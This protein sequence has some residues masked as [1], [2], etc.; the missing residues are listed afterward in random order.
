MACCIVCETRIRA[1]AAGGS[2]KRKTLAAW[3]RGG[4]EMK[5]VLSNLKLD[6][7]GDLIGAKYVWYV[8]HK[9]DYAED[10]SIQ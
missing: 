6:K 5:T 10:D 3:L 2:G 7:K 1:A 9:G 4:N 8:F